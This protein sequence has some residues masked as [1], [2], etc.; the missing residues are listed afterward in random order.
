MFLMIA[1]VRG[2]VVSRLLRMQIPAGSL[3]EEP[4]RSFI[5]FFLSKDANY[6]VVRLGPRLPVDE[7]EAM[8]PSPQIT[9]KTWGALGF[10]PATC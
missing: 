8:A 7:R 10:E 9:K 2:V 6:F 3:S 4:Y 5:L 1:G